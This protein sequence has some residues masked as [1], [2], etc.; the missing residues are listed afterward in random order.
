MTQPLNPVQVEE[1]IL[2]L[3]NRI[4]KGIP[5]VSAAEKEMV[6]AK[7]ALDRA[8]AHA[9]LTVDGTARERDSRVELRVEDERDAYDIAYL[10]FRD[11]E[12][13]MKSLTNQLSAV[14]SVGRS[15]TQMYGATR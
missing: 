7:R 5:V 15:V 13:L 12:R 3:S 14:Q 9:Y 1:L 8:Q 10:K 2:D 11:S 6:D 4:A